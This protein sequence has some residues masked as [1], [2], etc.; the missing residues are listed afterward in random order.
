MI[1]LLPLKTSQR[2]HLYE[3]I[4]PRHTNNNN[5][6]D[7]NDNIINKTTNG[8][9]CQRCSEMY[10]ASFVKYRDRINNNNYNSPQLQ[11]PEIEIDM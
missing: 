1:R 4:S 10:D 7:N 2:Y 5:V 8:K 9:T 3:I 6:D 11:Y